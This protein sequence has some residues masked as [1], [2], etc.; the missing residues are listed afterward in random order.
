MTEEV[1]MRLP[2]QKRREKFAKVLYLCIPCAR[3]EQQLHIP[4]GIILQGLRQQGR[5]QAVF[6]DVK[7]VTSASKR[8]LC[9]E[10]CSYT[11]KKFSAIRRDPT[12]AEHLM[13]AVFPHFRTLKTFKLGILKVVVSRGMWRSQSEDYKCGKCVPFEGWCTAHAFN[14]ANS[15]SALCQ[16]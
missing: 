6:Q 1:T 12:G 16:L 3:S 9:Y 5:L 15:V 4:V 2:D 8:G 11:C 7:A 14:G 13:L 10:V